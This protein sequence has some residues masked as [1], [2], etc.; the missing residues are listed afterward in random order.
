MRDAGTGGRLDISWTK[1]PETDLKRYTVRYGTTPGAPTAT[2]QAAPTATGISLFG[3]QNGTR[4]YVSLS[5]TN[6][7]DLESLPCVEL[8]DV[9]HIFLGIAPPRA[10]DDLMVNLS[11]ADLVLSWSQPTVDIYGRP[12]TVVGYRVYRGTTP[13]FAI[14]PA[15]P[16]ATLNS[17]ATVTWTHTGGAGLAGNAY[18]VVTA[19][20]SAGLVS[21]AGRDLPN[22]VGSLDVTL[23]NLSTVHLSWLPVTTDVQGLPTLI[24]H[25]QVHVTP[26]PVS[27]GQLGPG[28]LFLDNVTTTSADLSLPTGTKFIS[29]LAV[30]NR[31]NL[32]PF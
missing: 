2:V 23:P 22:G 25:Y 20:D 10:I 16:F 15:A 4:Y 7:S 18:Y 12:T 19:V 13:N 29:V 9:P 26:T 28:T 3:L 17:G 6:T 14:N 11:G 24:D 30:D 1:N 27:R 21:G 8:S 5:A 31:G 32:S